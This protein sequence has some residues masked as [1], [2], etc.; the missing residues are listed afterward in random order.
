MLHRWLH[1][2]LNEE[3]EIIATCKWLQTAELT[4]SEHLIRRCLRQ[5]MPATGLGAAGADG[6]TNCD[7]ERRMSFNSEYVM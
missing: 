5:E 3:A 4:P 1:S 7:F 6:A 2:K